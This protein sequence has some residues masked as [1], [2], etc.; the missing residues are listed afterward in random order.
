[1]SGVITERKKGPPFYPLSWKG[2]P[3]V[4]PDFEA[5]AATIKYEEKDTHAA[6][7]DRLHYRALF[8]E[9]F[10]MSIKVRGRSVPTTFVRGHCWGC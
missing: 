5:L 10:N 2:M 8:E 3:D 9:H 4:G 6:I 1:M 7:L